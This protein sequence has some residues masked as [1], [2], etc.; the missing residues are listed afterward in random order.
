MT[1]LKIIRVVQKANFNSNQTVT[2]QTKYVFNRILD[3]I[4][5]IKI[6]TASCQI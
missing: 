6:K 4:P 2:S 3:G 1:Y 5:S